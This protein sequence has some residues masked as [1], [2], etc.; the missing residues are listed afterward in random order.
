[1]QR[2]PTP[3]P[4]LLA[5]SWLQSPCA[6]TAH[7]SIKSLSALPTP[8]ASRFIAEPRFIPSLSMYP[9][10]DV[11]DRLIAEKITYRFVRCAWGCVRACMSTCVHE[12]V[13]ACMRSC[14]CV[15]ACAHTPPLGTKRPFSSA[16]APD[17]PFPSSLACCQRCGGQ[18]TTTPP[19]LPRALLCC[20]QEAGGG[21]VLER[22]WCCPCSAHR[23][24]TLGNTTLLCPA[25][26][27]EGP[28]DV[29]G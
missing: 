8:C 19:H 18:R 2:S 15:R 14:M 11:G 28:P 17:V 10:F 6:P 4:S 13:C 27:V 9:S 20:R 3:I 1:M 24:P 7:H 22:G 16:Q 29:Q 25:E 26:L 12:H 23:P 21:R 5:A